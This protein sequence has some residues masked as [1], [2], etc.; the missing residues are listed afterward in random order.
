MPFEWKKLRK[1][2][3]IAFQEFTGIMYDGRNPFD[4]EKY[5]SSIRKL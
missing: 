1:F 5:L 4:F 2:T 3:Y